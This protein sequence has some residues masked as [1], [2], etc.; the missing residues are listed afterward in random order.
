MARSTR[1]IRLETRTARLRLP[2]GVRHH[3]AI[4]AGVALGY[5][6]TND[7]YGAWHV[8]LLIGPDKYVYRQLGSADDFHDAD[9]EKTLT[10]F[11]AQDRARAI[12]ATQ[13]GTAASV[14]PY[15]VA[16]AMADYITWY[17]AHRKSLRTTELN[18]NAH[19]VPALGQR[20]VEQLTTPELRKWHEALATA[21]RRKRKKQLSKITEVETNS[22]DDGDYMR[23]RQQTA[24]RI[25]TILK[26]ALNMAYRDEHVKSDGAW[27][28]V[29]PFRAV[30]RA[31][32]RALS[33]GECVRLMNACKGEYRNLVKGALLTGC[34]YGEIVSLRVE[35]YLPDAR[36]IY[37]KFSK[38]D[39]PRHVP[40]PSEGEKFFSEMTTGKMPQDL[41]FV[42]ND[43]TPWRKNHQVRPLLTAC[44]LA[45]IVP[46]ITFH[47]LRHTYASLLA[48]AGVPLQAIAKV[49]GHADTRITEQHYAHLQPSFISEVVRAAFP[50]LEGAPHQP[51]LAL[52][53]KMA[54]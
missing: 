47:I 5:R 18:I 16:D 22:T 54:A 53:M 20:H 11:Q 38:S 17:T 41:I 13:R 36:S 19:V 32:V 26:A 25:L 44:N 33:V 39:K 52:P 43:G 35:D 10:Y 34:R 7:G 27:R 40:L 9:G 28:R 2:I 51:I 37:I 4:A 48:M 1:D 29:K 24:N 45:N 15:T 21:P 6:R 30:N 50:T 3:R 12:M 8:R 49:L 23:R 46:A 14:K 42:R 31:R